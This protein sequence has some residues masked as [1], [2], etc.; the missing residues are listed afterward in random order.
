[1]DLTWVASKVS[2]APCGIGHGQFAIAAIGAGELIA[3]FG[4]SVMTM[5][6]FKHLPPE[7]QHYPYQIYDDP[8][9]LLGPIRHEDIGNGEYFNHRC[10]PNA[11]F[12]GTQHLVAMRTIAPGEEIT[13]DYATC[14]TGDWGDMPCRCGATHCRRFITG[15]DWRRP[16]LQARYKG[17]FVPYIEDKI[18]RLK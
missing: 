11:G 7:L 5:E 4:G 16:D 13:F 10:D 1:M 12:Q 14:M 6:Q 9:L 15:N 2:S 17:H 3:V 18:A 8:E